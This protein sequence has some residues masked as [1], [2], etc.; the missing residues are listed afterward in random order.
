MWRRVLAKHG[1]VRIAT[2]INTYIPCA[3]TMLEPA[4]PTRVSG[5]P[6]IGTPR[7]TLLA[8]FRRPKL[9]A[10]VSAASVCYTGAERWASPW[11]G[12]APLRAVIAM[13]MSLWRPEQDGMKTNVGN[14][15][16]THARHSILIMMMRLGGLASPEPVTL[17]FEMYRPLQKLKRYPHPQPDASLALLTSIDLAI[18]LGLPRASSISARSSSSSASRPHARKSCDP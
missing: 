17:E 6:K 7:H 10:A 9:E 18:N 14:K 11:V 2:R 8:G 12:K 16:E 15:N 13:Q 3:Y 4:R 1:R 5:R